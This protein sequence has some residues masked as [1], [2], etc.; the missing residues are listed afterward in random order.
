MEKVSSESPALE[1]VRASVETSPWLAETSKEVG[2]MTM[3]GGSVGSGVSVPV[4][5]GV[6]VV[7]GVGVTEPVGVGVKVAVGVMSGKGV[8]EG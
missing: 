6:K 8:A 2:V 3:S 5:V 7:V 4:G 1:I